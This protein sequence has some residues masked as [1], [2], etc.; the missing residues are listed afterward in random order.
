MNIN[1]A[2]IIG[3]ITRQ[4]ELKILPNGTPVASF[5]VATNRVYTKDGQKHEDTEFH[6]IVVFGRQAESCNQ[7]LQQGQEVAIEG[8]IQTRS[9]ESKDGG[10]HYRTE[11][12][13]E[14]VQFGSRAGASQ[15]ENKGRSTNQEPTRTQSSAPQTRKPDPVIEYP[16][17]DIDPD[18]IP[19]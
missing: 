7:W 2:I 18:D 6:N 12:L 5:S 3:R 8:R 9:W 19:F 10:K 14:N 4:P 11:I 17:D 13:A 16:D 1:K 15:T